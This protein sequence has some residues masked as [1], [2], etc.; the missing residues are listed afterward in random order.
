[1]KPP[2]LPN[3]FKLTEYNRNR[4]FTYTPRYYDERK[5]RLEKRRKE[6]EAEMHA[7]GEHGDVRPHLLRERIQDAWHRKEMRRQQGNSGRRLLL[8]LAALI[9][10][11]YYL[12]IK[13]GF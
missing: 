4:Q 7:R 10:L 8:I 1:M 11:L 13:L 12:Y 3:I 9:A 2:R 6:I 5:E